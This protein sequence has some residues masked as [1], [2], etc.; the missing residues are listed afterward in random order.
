MNVRQSWSRLNKRYVAMTQRERLL[1]ALAVVFG[2]LL[3]GYTLFVDPQSARAKGMEATLAAES[4]NVARLQVEVAGMQQQLAVDPDAAR[5]V[6][7]AALT[8]E[9]GK[10]DEQLRQFSS[11]LVRPEQ[12][13]G[14]L[15]S[16]LSRHAGLRLVSLKT[17]APQSVL[18]EA[19]IKEGEVKPAERSFD[20]FRHG[21]EIRLEGNY[22]QLQAYLTQLEKLQQKLLWGQLSYRVIDY[23]RAEMSLVVYTLSPDQT[24]LAL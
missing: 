1:I 16:L 22:G 21:V 8:A 4:A 10:L 19:T 13:N 24:W 6:D 14:L 2:P 15:E 3:I 12:M 17:L 23:P 5:K 18:P 11:V 9:R 20:L 7:L